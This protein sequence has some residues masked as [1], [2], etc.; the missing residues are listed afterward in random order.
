MKMI[1]NIPRIGMIKRKRIE[2]A[3]DSLQRLYFIAM[4][5]PHKAIMPKTRIAIPPI[6]KTAIVIPST[7]PI[8]PGISAAPGPTTHYSTTH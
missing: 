4:V 3:S 2:P 8:I 7:W 1:A 5:P 6:R